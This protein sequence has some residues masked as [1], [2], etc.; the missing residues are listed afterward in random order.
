MIDTIKEYWLETVLSAITTGLGVWLRS[1]YKKFRRYQTDNEA[2]KAA[3]RSMVRDRLIQAYR[4][5]TK[6]EHV[7]FLERESLMNMHTQYKALG[8]NG[9]IDNL[10][11]E[12]LEL[13]FEPGKAAV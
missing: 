4:Y 9:A 6:H 1:L 13:P 5:H 12:L 7:P 11:E 10:M 8:G 3:V 2:L